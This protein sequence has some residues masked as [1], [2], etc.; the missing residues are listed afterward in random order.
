M[1]G[2]WRSLNSGR[3]CRCKEA[4]RCAVVQVHLRRVQEVGDLS[5]TARNLEDVRVELYGCIGATGCPKLLGSE[6]GRELH[7][8]LRTPAQYV[9]VRVIR[10]G[11]FTIQHG[12]GRLIQPTYSES[13]VR[14][15]RYGTIPD[16]VLQV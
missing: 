2:E 8:R 14:I 13:W 7:N 4:K 15:H 6:D 5:L 3:R 1:H 10:D 11:H 16:D 9:Q 12:N